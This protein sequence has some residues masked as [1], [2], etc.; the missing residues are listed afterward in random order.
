M[1][2]VGD[3]DGVPSRA[4]SRRERVGVTQYICAFVFCVFFILWLGVC[5]SQ[6]V[7]AHLPAISS[8]HG[9]CGSAANRK[10]GTR[11]GIW[12]YAYRFFFRLPLHAKQRPEHR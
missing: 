10:S 11:G 7:G 8:P 1:V 6:V 3:K 5:F 12:E 9:S 2:I 4:S